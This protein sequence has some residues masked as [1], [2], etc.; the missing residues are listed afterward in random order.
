MQ[1]KSRLK[2]PLSARKAGTK[3]LKL[4]MWTFFL[5]LPKKY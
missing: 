4:E 5:G 1:L 3:E 2:L